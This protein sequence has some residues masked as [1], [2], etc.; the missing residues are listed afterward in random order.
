MPANGGTVRPLV[1]NAL[2]EVALRN[3]PRGARVDLAK[4]QMCII[5]MVSGSMQIDWASEKILLRAGMFCMFPA[6]GAEAA[7]RVESDASWLEI[8]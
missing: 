6:D 4:S 1:K 7:V 2:F 5:G 8:H 3:A